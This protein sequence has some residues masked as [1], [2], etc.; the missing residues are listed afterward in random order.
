M[1]KK[2]IHHN[3][4]IAFISLK[5]FIFVKFED[6]TCQFSFLNAINCHF[7]RKKRV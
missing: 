5:G 1:K 7:E 3:K 2:K 4:N 6:E